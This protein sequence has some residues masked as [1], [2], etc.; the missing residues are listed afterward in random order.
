[1]PV[2]LRP[3]DYEFWL[4]PAFKKIDSVSEMLKPFETALMRR[5]TVSM[6]VNN[7]QNDDAECAEPVEPDA[8]P[9]QAQL[10]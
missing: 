1:M 4:D 3:A 8:S 5:Y 6:R 10:F 2:I 7:V 9:A